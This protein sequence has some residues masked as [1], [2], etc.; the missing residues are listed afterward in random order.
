MQATGMRVLIKKA[1]IADPRSAFYGQ[2]NDILISNGIIEHIAADIDTD[3]DK[4]L[5]Y[6]GVWVSPGFTDVFSH[7]CD[8]GLEHKE[9]L[10]SG[11]QAARAGGYTRVMLIPNTR[12][13]IHNKSQVEY[14]VQKGARTGIEVLPIGA[15]S[16]QCEGKDLAE[17]Y[18]MYQSGAAA[19]SDGTNPVQNSQ[20]LLK[21]LQYVKSFGGTIIQVPDEQN[22]SRT[23]LV[24]EGIVS[25]RLALPGKPAISD[26]LM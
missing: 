12:P 13:A 26:T 22:L 25:T 19:F 3:A 16:Q 6:E 10:E 11:A 21:A 9:T 23:G 2:T 18:D 7:F 1:T 4:I 14:I 5:T 17:M 24:N 8:P 15:I 20:V